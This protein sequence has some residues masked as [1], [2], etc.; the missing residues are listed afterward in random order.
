MWCTRAPRGRPRTTVAT[1]P[2]TSVNDVVL[3]GQA[4]IIF[5]EKRCNF[6]S[7]YNLLRDRHLRLRL[8]RRVRE[9]DCL[10]DSRLRQLQLRIAFIALRDNPTTH[11]TSDSQ[12]RCGAA[13]RGLRTEPTQPK[14]LSRSPT[15]PPLPIQSIR[16]ATSTWSCA[17][18]I[19]PTSL[20]LVWGH[21]W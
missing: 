17:C 7:F 4:L 19:R 1:I 11:P 5:V 2:E 16:S 21:S 13:P 8:G 14:K 9:I 12:A 10:T 18:G 15:P 6:F 3:R 20:Q